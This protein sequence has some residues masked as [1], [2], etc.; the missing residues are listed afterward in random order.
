MQVRITDGHLQGFVKEKPWEMEITSNKREI[1][2]SAGSNNRESTVYSFLSN[3]E[4]IEAYNI[5][6][7]MIPTRE[8]I[9]TS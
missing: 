8:K 7:P 1:R 6:E 2:I 5:T 9:Y 4:L 3:Q